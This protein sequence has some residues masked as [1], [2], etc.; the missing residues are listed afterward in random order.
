M[1]KICMVGTGYVGL[2]TGACLADFGN[3]VTCVDVDEAK[4]SSLKSGQIPFYEPGLRELVG[5]NMGKNRL[6]FTTALPESIQEDEIVFI[7]V[8]TPMG[9]GG[10]VDLSAVFDV[11]HTIAENL[12]GYKIV[13]NKSTVP[14][15]TGARVRQII[16][17]QV[18][19][20]VAFD[21]VSNPEFLR[22]GSAIGDFMHPDRVVIGTSSER[23]RKVMS[24]IYRPLYLIETPIVR[25]TV[26]TAEMIK[27][28]SNAFLATKISF[29]NEVANLCEKVGADIQVVAKAVGLDGRIGPKFLHAGAGYGGSCFPKDTMGLLHVAETASSELQ[30]VKA[31][32]AANKEQKERMVQK[33]VRA[34]GDLTGKTIGVLGLSFKPRTDD[35]REAPALYVVQRLQEEGARIRAYD[36]V[37]MSNA[38]HVVRQVEFCDDAYTVCQGSDAL[39]FMTEWN[40]FRELD[41]ARIKGLLKEPVI[42]DTRNIYDPE[43]MENLGFRYV[44]VGRGK[45]RRA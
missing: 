22:E 30:I 35:V 25:T 38:G 34:V 27:Y 5:R 45:P 21:V 11:A 3:E 33:V 42:V 9:E 13:V 17:E 31:A 26:E 29:I 1:R 2:V 44:G 36:P 12:N 19:G 24:E 20:K 40:E 43:E 37:A 15:G 28:T 4:I 16:Q 32:V 8:G 18:Q 6:A 41:M 10:A 7:A 14:V 23:A 39:V